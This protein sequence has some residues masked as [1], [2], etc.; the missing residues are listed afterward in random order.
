MHFSTTTLLFCLLSLLACS[1]G[2]LADDPS[3]EFLGAYQACQ[4]GERLERD[5]HPQDAL[6][7][8]WIAENLLEEI[9]RADPSWQQPVLEY[10]LKETR[11]GIK[12]LQPGATFSDAVNIPASV[13]QIRTPQLQILN[14]SLKESG[15]GSKKLLISII[16]KT[17]RPFDISQERIVVFFYDQVG[18]E[19]FTSKAQITSKWQSWLNGK[20]Q[21]LEVTYFP[22]SVNPNVQFA[23]YVIAVYF[24][25]ELQDCQSEPSILKQ[26]FP[27]NYFIG[28]D[29]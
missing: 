9:V 24:K 28:Y 14:T 8:Y 3:K 19:I 6:K 26:H 25:G 21:L 1:R 7:K 2:L 18:K 29:K 17:N 10:R 5:G 13:Q 15:E 22:E 4:E 12:R 16:S 27:P 23:G 20:P 11:N